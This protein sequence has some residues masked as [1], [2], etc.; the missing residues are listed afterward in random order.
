MDEAGGLPRAEALSGDILHALYDLAARPERLQRFLEIWEAWAAPQRLLPPAAQS[1]P[2]AHIALALELMER[3]SRA[4]QTFGAGSVLDLYP[5]VATFLADGGPRIAKVNQAATGALSLCD[6]A[7]LSRL[8]LDIPDLN[9]LRQMIR[10]VAEGR[11]EGP[12]TLRLRHQGNGGLLICRIAVSPVPAFPPM[13]LIVTS[14]LNWTEECSRT[15]RAA[16]GLSPAEVD[17]TRSICRGQSLAEVAAQRGRSAETVRTQL[18]T[19][20]TKTETH[21]QSDLVRV[22]LTLLQGAHLPKAPLPEA[23]SR[24]SRAGVSRIET[25][26]LRLPGGR[27]LDYLEFGTPEGS[28]LLFLHSDWGLARWP[29][30][31]EAAAAARG[32]RVIVPFREGYGASSLL[33]GS[34]NQ[35]DGVTADLSALLD[36]LGVPEA[37][38]LSLGGDLR[39]AL[40]L[41][42]RRPDLVTA[43]LG[44]APLL[45]FH[46]A[47][48]WR[49]LTGWPRWLRANARFT[50]DLMPLLTRAMLA[51]SPAHAGVIETLL[52]AQGPDQIAA[53]DREMRSALQAGL[54]QTLLRPQKGR[55]GALARGILA[56]EADWSGLLAQ[57]VVPLHLLHGTADPFAPPDTFSHPLRRGNPV[58]IQSL[59]EAGHLLMLTHWH[60]ILTKLDSIMRAHTDR[61]E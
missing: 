54:L 9:K 42:G 19:V 8:P 5:G 3:G 23:Q 52:T 31:A 1:W 35:L 34:V 24:P 13:A 12:M 33:P 14:E 53:T 44:A 40:N 26:V 25:S 2:L 6:G 16:F 39:F 47:T 29:A 61:A 49:A 30:R 51:A 27:R 37:M 38:V 28:P 10:L 32:L 21:G 56:T 7:E 59:P 60:V 58:A 46:E 20:L 43:I 4:E 15:L 57:S 18:R 22:A 55:S 48:D 11:M 50:P 45:P 41:A 17:I 36:H